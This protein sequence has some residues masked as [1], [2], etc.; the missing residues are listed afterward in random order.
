MG[1]LAALA[2]AVYV[3]AAGL[4]VGSAIRF[5]SSQ[6]AHM[7]GDTLDDGPTMYGRLA[8]PRTTTVSRRPSAPNGDDGN[9]EPM[10]SLELASS[11]AGLN[12]ACGSHALAESESLIATAVA[13]LPPKRRTLACVGCV[14]EIR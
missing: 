1:N 7:R 8:T 10:W 14:V 6:D 13:M 3:G 12:A 4:A 2:D 5:F 11:W 9:N